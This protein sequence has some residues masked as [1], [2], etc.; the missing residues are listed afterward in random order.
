MRTKFVRTMRGGNIDYRRMGDNRSRND[1][2]MLSALDNY[3]DGTSEE[4]ARR[5]L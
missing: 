5:T 3:S 4:L 1:T 2:Y